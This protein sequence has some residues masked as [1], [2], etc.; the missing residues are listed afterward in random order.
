MFCARKRHHFDNSLFTKCSQVQLSSFFHFEDTKLFGKRCGK[1]PTESQDR[2]RGS[3]SMSGKYL[4][5][6]ATLV[7]QY[8][9][10]EL[11]KAKSFCFAFNKS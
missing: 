9:Y 5:C 1:L 10:S 2:I 8:F 7:E 6:T 3:Q 11:L 4:K